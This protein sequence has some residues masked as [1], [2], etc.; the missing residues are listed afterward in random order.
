MQNDSPSGLVAAWV[1]ILSLLLLCPCPEPRWPEHLALHFVRWN[2]GE[3][4]QA[5]R[6][7]LQRGCL[8]SWGGLRVRGGLDGLSLGPCPQ[9]LKSRAVH[10]PWGSQSRC[11]H[12]NHWLQPVRLRQCCACGL[13]LGSLLCYSCRFSKCAAR[14][15]RLRS[16]G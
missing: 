1:L 15:S 2:P 8:H 4:L 5:C 11:W 12:Q 13:Q 9:K 14:G 16:D 6:G 3:A 7:G 10:P